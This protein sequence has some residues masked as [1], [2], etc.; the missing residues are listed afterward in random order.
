MRLLQ[1]LIGYFAG[2]L[3]RLGLHISWAA[4][5]TERA[6]LR[7]VN[8]DDSSEPTNSNGQGAP[9]PY[10]KAAWSYDTPRL[11]YGSAGTEHRDPSIQQGCNQKRSIDQSALSLN[12]NGK[13]LYALYLQPSASSADALISYSIWCTLHRSRTT[14]PTTIRLVVPSSSLRTSVPSRSTSNAKPFNLSF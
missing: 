13:D 7:V 9:L 1:R 5:A 14:S 12:A 3:A 4:I 10:H 11:K 2:L 8:S 6:S